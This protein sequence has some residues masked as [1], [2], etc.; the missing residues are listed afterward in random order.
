MEDSM[1]KR[2]FARTSII[3]DYNTQFRLG[4]QTYSK[5]QV[6]NIGTNG[7]CVQLPIASAQYLKGKPVLENMILFHGDSKKYSL[8]GRVAWHDDA[9][10][11]TGKHVTAGVE[12]LETPTE[13]SRE[14]AEYVAVTAKTNR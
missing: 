12:F 2:K 3:S 7:C 10:H 11:G 6:S 5:V 13:C 14:I 9:S 1:E 4:G 8:K